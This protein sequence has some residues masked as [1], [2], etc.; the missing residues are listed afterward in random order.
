MGN[1]TDAQGCRHA[2]NACN[3]VEKGDV[4]VFW[5]EA[6]TAKSFLVRRLFYVGLA[7]GVLAFGGASAFL[8]DVPSLRP[9]GPLGSIVAYMFLVVLGVRLGLAPARTIKLPT[10]ERYASG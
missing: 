7:G 3:T 4:A 9:L 1:S 2:Y 8:M 6:R 10:R 5:A